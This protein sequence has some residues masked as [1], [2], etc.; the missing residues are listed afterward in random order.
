M[1]LHREY[2]HP[3]PPATFEHRFDRLGDI[4]VQPISGGHQVK[5]RQISARGYSDPMRS[6]FDRN[7]DNSHST[8]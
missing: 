4:G 3:L 1:T 5:T 7:P 2:L 6:A 8:V